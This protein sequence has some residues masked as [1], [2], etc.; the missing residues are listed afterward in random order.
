MHQR[1]LTVIFFFVVGGCHGHGHNGHDAKRPENLNP[2]QHE[3]QLLTTALEGAVKHI[4]LGELPKIE[5]GLHAVHGAREQTEA[6]LRDGTYRPPK[7]ADHVAKFFELDKAF[8]AT[9]EELAHAA[10]KNDYD[11]TV[12]HF[13]LAMRGCRECHEMFKPEG[14]A[15]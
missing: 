14:A 8:H 2:V 9:L 11:A 4:A 10:A 3:M 1:L 7:N 6:A 5:H 15:P 13:S 12:A